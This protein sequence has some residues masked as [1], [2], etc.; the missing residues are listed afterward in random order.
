MN[1][2]LLK[3]IV[4]EQKESLKLRDKGFRRDILSK[5][6]SFLSLKHNIVITGHRRCGKSTLLLQIMDTLFPSH[7]FQY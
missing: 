2:D 3:K 6:D 7:L 5:I 4:L 1:K